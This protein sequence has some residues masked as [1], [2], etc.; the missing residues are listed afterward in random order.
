M[1]FDKKNN[2]VALSSGSELEA[3]LAAL[4]TVR[5]SSLHFKHTDRQIAHDL[6]D[7]LEAVE[8]T[9]SFANG[10]DRLVL[11]AYE[12]SILIRGAIRVEKSWRLARARTLMP[13][14]VASSLHDI[15]GLASV[16]G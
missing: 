8:S 12:T 5:R 14:S 7:R 10:Q 4:A 2:S 13:E 6:E 16:D 3:A 15:T 11:D 1:E 9:G